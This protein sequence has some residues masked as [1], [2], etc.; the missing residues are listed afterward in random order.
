MGKMNTCPECGEEFKLSWKQKGKMSSIMKMLKMI[1]IAGIEEKDK[2]L[3]DCCF[4]CWEKEMKA[5]MK[6]FAQALGQ[7]AEMW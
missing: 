3:K 1:K 5:T 6:P 2:E 7:S 4:L